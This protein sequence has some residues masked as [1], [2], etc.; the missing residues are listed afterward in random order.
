MRIGGEFFVPGSWTDPQHRGRELFLSAVAA[1]APEAL[2]AL[3][4]DVGPAARNA[5]PPDD[6]VDFERWFAAQVEPLLT[7]WQKRWN[8][9]ESWVR[10]AAVQTLNDWSA[11]EGLKT[12]REVWPAMDSLTADLSGYKEQ[13]FIFT[14]I[15]WISYQETRKAAEAR[16]RG[17]F[18]DYLGGYLDA[19][20]KADQARGMVRSP[21]KRGRRGEK[22]DMH[23]EWLA[24]FQVQEW[25]YGKIASYYQ[26]SPRA[27]E[28]AVRE[29]S[30]L[31]G[32]TRRTLLPKE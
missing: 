32:L 27:V 1:V 18:D 5:E 29:T 22:P 2:A 12:I 13:E 8:L 4:R 25:S 3:E 6:S 16:L 23:F 7:P 20:E 14:A 26:V 28:D 11:E 19:V 31:I 15:P 21:E 10:T 17:A 30:E 24:R 9:G